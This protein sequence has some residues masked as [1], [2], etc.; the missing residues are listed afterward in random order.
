[1]PVHC[2]LPVTKTKVQSWVT[3]V[4]VGGRG[5]FELMAWDLI[6]IE[7]DNSKFNT[8]LNCYF[9]EKTYTYAE[10]LFTLVVCRQLKSLLGNAVTGPDLPILGLQAKCDETF[11]GVRGDV[12]PGILLNFGSLKQHFPHFEDTFEQ[13]IKSEIPFFNR[14]SRHF[15]EIFL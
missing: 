2:F 10:I 1:M 4:C 9:W 7:L 5:I 12:P 3:S 14:V 6:E 11:L 13:N 8:F 15:K